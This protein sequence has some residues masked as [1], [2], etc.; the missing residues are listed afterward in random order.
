MD[1]LKVRKEVD[2]YKR[3]NFPVNISIIQHDGVYLVIAREHVNWI[4]LENEKQLQFFELLHS[5]SLGEALELFCGEKKDAVAVVT[6]LEAKRFEATNTKSIK[7]EQPSIFIYLTSEC[8]MQC[9]HCYMYA[10]KKKHNEL[11]FDEIKTILVEYKEYGGKTVCFSGGEICMRSDLLQ[12]LQEASQLEYKIKLMTNGTLWTSELID[13]VVPLIDSIQISIDGYDEAENARIRGK[14]NFQKAL[15]TVD[16]FFSKGTKVTVAITP[17]F[18]NELKQKAQK[19]GEFGRSLLEKYGQDNFNLLFSTNLLVGREISFSNEENKEY[20]KIM[21]DIIYPLCYGDAA[22][23]KNFID[24]SK[25]SSRMNLCAYGNPY[26]S[27]TGDVAFCAELIY[28]HPVANIREDSFS[29]ILKLREKARR[30][31][32]VNNLIPCRECELKYICGGGCRT[33]FF[34][35]LIRCDVGSADES[36]HFER[37]CTKKDREYFYKL[38]IQTN[39]KLFL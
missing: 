1:K 32:D 24:F 30:L 26:I 6:Q 34:E 29:K 14:G 21:K 12:I 16:S 18:D 39:S 3:Y 20:E 25:L 36:K 10:G 13:V 4:V 28:T 38:M 23:E 31:A 35:E 2:L 27:S 9:P 17:F 33:A 22:E 15:D 11:S 7:T 8:N 37:S 19:F 5:Y